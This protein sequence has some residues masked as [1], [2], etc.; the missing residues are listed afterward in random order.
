MVHEP[1]YPVLQ[2]RLKGN[3][4]LFPDELGS[5]MSLGARSYSPTN[6]NFGKV[7]SLLVVPNA[8]TD[9]RSNFIQT[10]AGN[11]TYLI[12]LN[13][14]NGNFGNPTSP[15]DLASTS[16]VPFFETATYFGDQFAGPKGFGYHYTVE[17]LPR[18]LAL[19]DVLTNDPHVRILHRPSPLLVSYVREILGASMAGRMESL[20]LPPEQPT[21]F[22]AQTL[23]VAEPTPCGNPQPAPVHLTRT[24][25]QQALARTFPSVYGDAPHNATTVKKHIVLLRRRVKGFKRGGRRIV[26]N[27]RELERSLRRVLPRDMP[28][29]VF[30]EI[31]LPPAGLEQWHIFRRAHL[32][33]APH[34]AGLANLL[35]CDAGTPVVEFLA[36]SDKEWNVC[37][38]YLALALGLEYHPLLMYPSNERHVGTATRFQVDVERVTSVVLEILEGRAAAERKQT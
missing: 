22:F 4:Y 26:D 35:A 12:K 18:L 24:L 7:P 19:R 32:V 16:K 10:T 14:C 37:F 38:W 13:G 11:T 30:D 31:S 36:V 1:E 5:N 9:V 28:L 2:S 21:H 25:I 34:G 17:H 27:H 33:I 20:K 29:V 3:S 15:F 6:P 23:L 8:I